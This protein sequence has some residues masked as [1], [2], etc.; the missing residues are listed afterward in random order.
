M[1]LE[2][3]AKDL[4]GNGER[5]AL[6]KLACSEAGAKLAAHVDGGAI[7]A[8][9]KSGDMK[10]LSSILRDILAT[11]E[12]KNFAAEVKKAVKRDEW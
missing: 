4:L 5:E 6:G 9:A 7:E 2:E 1:K 8:A 12:G 11:P 10:A 3:Y